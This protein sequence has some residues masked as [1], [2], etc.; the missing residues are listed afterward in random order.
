[1]LDEK[2]LNILRHNKDSYISG[3][4]LTKLADISRAAIWKHIEKLREEGYEIEAVPHLGYKLLSIPDALIPSE[5][6]WKLKTKILGRE[7]ISYKKVDSTNNI[8]YQ[9][10]EK[11]IKEG[12]VILA[13]EQ[14][15]G[16]GRRGRSWV[17]PSKG[18]IYMSCIL[19]PAI[20]PV[21]IPK[22]TLL[23]AVA[24]AKAI[25]LITGLEVLIKWPNDIFLDGKKLCGILTE[26]KAEQ[27]SVGFVVIGIG[28]NVTTPIK[29]L[30]KG[31][32]S[33]KEELRRAGMEASISRIEL[34]KK[35]LE[36]LEEYY[37]L[38]IKKG[39]K[40][41]IDAWKDLSAMIGSRVKIILPN[42]SFEGQVHDIDPDGA[43]VVRLDSG[44]L[45]KVSS[46]DVVMVRG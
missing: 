27:D 8:A 38:L 31:A 13:E 32:S 20:S 11:G 26:M 21:E 23:A 18:G 24:V 19:K 34:T 25:R 36:I 14:A 43:L 6:K 2:I 39:F 37:N 1:M 33:L 41:I 46:G 45:E 22:I 35:I 3:E 29:N 5:I 10:A 12:V 7:V 16:K 9:L 42:R 30:P 15:K 44:V 17:S 4:E 40:P 28:V